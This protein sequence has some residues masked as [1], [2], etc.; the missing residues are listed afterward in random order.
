M[1]DLADV[2]ELL[3]AETSGNYQ[4]TFQ[5]IVQFQWCQSLEA[6]GQGMIRS[7]SPTILMGWFYTFFQ[8]P[9]F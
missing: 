9:P 8:T 5:V 2:L 6:L 1:K 7:L 4:L 3:Y